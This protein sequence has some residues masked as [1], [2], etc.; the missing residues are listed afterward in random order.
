MK[1]LLII[2]TLLLVTSAY[3]QVSID[4]YLSDFD[5]GVDMVET[6]YSGFG[7]KV[8][9]RT[10]A[11]YMAVKDSVRSSIMTRQTTLEDAFGC[12]L[13][14]FKD[15]H[16]REFS[17]A[18]RKYMDGPTDY[19]AFMDYAPCDVYGKVDDSCFLIRYTSCEWTSKRRHWINKAISSFKK[20]GCEHLILDLRGNKGGSTGTS[21]AFI[22]LLYDHD[23][24]YNGVVIRNTSTNLNFLRKAMRQDKNWQA[25]LD[26]AECSSDEYPILLE[27]PLV[28]Y[29][30]ASSL[31]KKAAIIIDNNTAS[32]AEELILIL[33]RVSDRVMVFG[34]DH[35][36]GCSDYSN[37]GMV[38]MPKSKN[39]FMLPLTCSLGL[40][41]TGIDA[42]GIIPDVII[43]C[44][45][46]SVLKDNID[47][48]CQWVAAFLLDK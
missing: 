46:P 5:Y 37:A 17:G 34:K 26:A 47:S 27:P 36:L 3:A 39:K 10:R 38:I 9:E 18:Q 43:D 13:A 32:C 48:W 8:T 16:L 7:N 35:S 28:H 22:K 30:K 33:Q 19:S 42:T 45:Y 4:D 2:I 29:K 24:L 21:D 23:G 1:R 11:S 40:P 15:Y 41:E 44:G 31:P 25:R 14:W 6:A 20:S 12:Y